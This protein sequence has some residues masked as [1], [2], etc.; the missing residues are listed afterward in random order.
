MCTKMLRSNE[1]QCVSR[2]WLS[3]FLFSWPQP[4]RMRN[5]YARNASEL[6]ARILLAAPVAV[7]DSVTGREDN[8]QTIAE[9]LLLANDTTGVNSQIVDFTQ[10]ANA[11]LTFDGTDF[12]FTPNPGFVGTTQFDY[13]VEDPDTFGVSAPQTVI[14][15]DPADSDLFGFAVATDGTRLVVGATRGDGAVADSGAAYVYEQ[16]GGMWVQVAKLT[17]SDGAAL[18]LFGWSVAIDGNTVVVGARLDDSGAGSAYVFEDA[19]AN[20]WSQTAKLTAQTPAAGDLFGF[21]VAIDGNLIA[22]GANK[23]DTANGTDAGSVWIFED[24][25]A[26]FAF[27]ESI[28]AGD[29]A[30]I[31]QFGV[32]VDLSGTT[33][34]VGSRFDDDQG[35]QSGSAYIYSIGSGSATQVAK[36]TASD[37]EFGDIFGFDVAIDGNTA[38]ISANSDDD[39]GTNAGAAYVFRNTGTW[40]QAQKL[41]AS[42]GAAGQL[43]GQSV[44]VDEAEGLILISSLQVLTDSGAGYLYRDTGSGYVQE[45]IITNPSAAAGDNYGRSVALTGDVVAL[46]ASGDDDAANGA[47]TVM[48]RQAGP[49]SDVGTVTV[50]VESSAVIDF[51]FDTDAGIT[52]ST[53]FFNDGV[54][55]YLGIS[56]NAGA[57]GDFDGQ[58]ADASSSFE[59]IYT[60]FSGGF[61][62]GQDLDRLGATLP[63]TLDWTGIDISGLVNLQFSG[64]FA[65]FQDANGAIDQDNDSIQ[66]QIQIDGGGYTTILAFE[67]AD[68][69]AAGRFNGIF[70]EDTNFD[71]TG[72]GTALT[73]AAQTFTKNIVGTGST[74][75][76]RLVVWVD[77]QDEDFAADNLQV[78]GDLAAPIANLFAIDSQTGS[79]LTAHSTGTEFTFANGPAWSQETQWTFLQGDVNADRRSD[80]IGINSQDELWVSLETMNGLVEPV[81]WG[82]WESGQ[83]A[84]DLNVGDFNGDGRDDVMTRGIDG[85]WRIQRS[86]G[87]GFELVTGPRWSPTAYLDGEAVVGD[88]NGDGRD[89]VAL[90]QTTGSWYVGYGTEDGLST[91]YAGRWNEI[92][93]TWTDIQVGDFNGDQRDDIIARTGDGSWYVLQMPTGDRFGMRNLSRWNS[94]LDWRDIAIGDFNGDGMDDVAGWD[95]RGLWWV[96]QGIESGFVRPV[97]SGRWSRSAEWVTAIGDFNGDGKDDI[98]GLQAATGAWWALLSLGDGFSATDFFGQTSPATNLSVIR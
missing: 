64:D 45:S 83:N 62:V 17:A 4:R 74:L 95:E 2:L 29:G 7:D 25:G 96:S 93:Y 10:P 40:T 98:V 3:T 19:G 23:D 20:N 13:T 86:T 85:A 22:V 47:G 12:T 14:A 82:S 54:H 71:G 97:Y 11:T 81:L 48:M 35:I 89:D 58:N 77:A 21:D 76:M 46:G 88:F 79:S 15:G 8:V 39:N 80:V 31:D 49:L 67:G 24:A 1:H 34:L 75:D 57:A 87:T 90:R 68:F 50:T 61:L 94:A 44:A 70:R 63:I 43:F 38:V 30:T 41:T 65:E 37:G 78:T 91:S 59:E 69:T 60:G 6:E 28:E 53:A 9:S 33:L 27:K 84:H 16:S 52:K 72:D 73:S 42:D 18:D 26:G 36:L 55:G 56:S 5:S 32:S 51:N 92:A 66:I